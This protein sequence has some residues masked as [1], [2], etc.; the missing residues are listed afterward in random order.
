[1]AGSPVHRHP[2]PHAHSRRRPGL[3]KVHHTW[4]GEVPDRTHF[5]DFMR[6]IGVNAEELHPCC[7]PRPGKLN[8]CWVS[9]REA[10]R[11]PVRY[12]VVKESRRIRSMSEPSASTAPHENVAL[13]SH[14]AT[15]RGRSVTIR[16]QS[17]PVTAKRPL[18][19]PAIS[20]SRRP[21]PPSR[22]ASVISRGGE[23]AERT[24]APPQ[25]APPL[26]AL[27]TQ[28]HGASYLCTSVSADQALRNSMRATLVREVPRESVAPAHVQD[29]ELWEPLPQCPALVPSKRPPP[30]SRNPTKP[31]L[32]R[33]P[34][35]AS[36]ETVSSSE[37]PETPRG[38]SPLHSP[39]HMLSPTLSNLEQKSRLRVPGQC[40]ACKRTGHNF[41]S[42]PA[43]GD[44]WCSR[45]CRIQAT[46]GRKHVCPSRK[47]TH[48]SEATSSVSL[49][50]VA[51]S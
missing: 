38:H 6:E 15:D 28:N 35:F 8:L 23:E 50:V 21:S 43:C 30:S 9:E 37:G 7:M 29:Q 10:E 48:S 45:E 12:T 31:N 14:P 3:V 46:A 24:P 19:P 11:V 47:D 13:T 18:S 39:S 16:R 51:D 32:S 2:A 25:K 41:P 49:E 40:V 26:I 34:S 27:Y 5:E 36:L 44:M 17:L 20:S 1:M 42:C 22:V 33:V 4:H